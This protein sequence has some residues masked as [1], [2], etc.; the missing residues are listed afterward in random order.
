VHYRDDDP[1]AIPTADDEDDLVG[2]RRG[3][4]AP[5]PSVLDDDDAEG[6]PRIPAPRLRRGGRDSG[7]GLNRETLVRLVRDIPAFI[8]LLARLMRDPRVSRLDRVIVGAVLAYFVAPVDLVP[9]LVFP[10]L[11][12]VDDIYFLALALSRLVNNA[13]TE[14]LLEHWDGEESSLELL[15]SGLDRASA[16]LPAPA[17]VLLGKR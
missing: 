17:R 16:I 15:L 5:R 1:P 10:V 4:S 7:S 8:K 9:D 6:A 3:A 2:P 12:Q 14:V 11:G 13:G